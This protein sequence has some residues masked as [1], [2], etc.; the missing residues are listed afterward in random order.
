MKD[1]YGLPAAKVK[2]VTDENSQAM[3]RFHTERAAESFRAAGAYETVI[4]PFVRSS[5]WHQMGT[6][7]MGTDPTSSVTDK[8]GR[9]HDI[10]NLYV[11]DSSTWVTSGGVNPA[12]TQAALAL[13]SCDSFLRTKNGAQNA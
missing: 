9:C 1:P 6:T 13:W 7:R 3:M 10:P 4:G 12:A 2:Y 8:F 11:F 5:G